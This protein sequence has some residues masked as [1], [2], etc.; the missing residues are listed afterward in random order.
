MKLNKYIFLFSLLLI[1][2]MFA[3]SLYTWGQVPAD[4]PI[5]VHWGPSGKPD[6]Y[7]GKVEGLLLLP[8]MTLLITG[9]L[10]V[11]PHFE[12]RRDN[13]MRSTQA[14][15]WFIV[16]LVGFMGSLHIGMNLTIL[17]RSFDI[18]RWGAMGLGLLF[19][20]MGNFMGK[21]RSNYMFGIRTPWTLASEQSWNKTH[22]LGG[23]LFFL[24]GVLLL[25]TGVF[26]KD[27]TIYVLIFSLLPMIVTLFAYSYWVWRQEN[28]PTPE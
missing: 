16:A 9:L 28:R 4:Q 11:V 22:R 12:P 7:G 23:K 1:M 3:L 26:L 18:N 15:H 27:W 6:R 20:V 25:I 5:P 14:Y 21:V 24:M 17:G 13:L 19:T 8:T 2:G 10:Y